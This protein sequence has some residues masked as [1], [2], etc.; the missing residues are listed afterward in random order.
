MRKL[1][2]AEQ[3]PTKYDPSEFERLR[4]EAEVG[5]LALDEMTAEQ[6]AKR[7]ERVI[8]VIQVLRSEKRLAA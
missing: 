2:G 1:R 3:K 5:N 8:T 7:L 4:L 6:L